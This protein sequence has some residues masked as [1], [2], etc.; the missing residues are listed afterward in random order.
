MNNDIIFTETIQI[1]DLISD[2]DSSN[3]FTIDVMYNYVP[4]LNLP[5]INYQNND[6]PI[7]YISSPFSSINHISTY[8]NL[9]SSKFLKIG[10]S[11][12]QEFPSN[13]KNKHEN[14]FHKI[15]PI[16]YQENCFLWIH[17]F[18]NPHKFNLID[19]EKNIFFNYSNFFVKQSNNF[20]SKNIDIIIICDNFFNISSKKWLKYYHNISLI[21]KS[22]PLLNNLNLK[23]TIVDPNNIVDK[24]SNVNYVDT[25]DNL[26]SLLDKSKICIIFNKHASFIPYVGNAL[27]RNNVI[28]MY[29]SILGEWNL[30]NKYTGS[31]FSDQKSLIDNLQFVYNNLSN[32]KPRKW[33]LKKH[34]PNLQ[35][36]NLHNT[37]SKLYKNNIQ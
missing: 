25:Y 32:F 36:Q 5:F 33:Y 12:Y 17:S 2:S 11:I 29:H 1:H 34:N 7:Y 18:K 6:L 23:I 27:V 16:D 21:N 26:N 20:H 10:L 13:I 8:N 28:L 35:I 3:D 9:L 14:D 22:L 30:I 37:I 19:Q 31:F 4:K 15:N 24:Y